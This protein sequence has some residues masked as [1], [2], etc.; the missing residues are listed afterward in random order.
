MNPRMT[1]VSV[2]GLC[3]ILPTLALSASS[4]LLPLHP[5]ATE[6]KAQVVLQ[7][8]QAQ[9]LT[10]ELSLQGL[11]SESVTI[12]GRTMTRLGI[13]AGGEAGAVGQAALPTITRLVAL[14][15]GS[16]VQAAITAMSRHDLGTMSLA[17]NLPILE[18]G[19]AAPTFDLGHY[20][21]A[22]A[23]TPSIEVGE[24]ALMHGL[25]V[26]PITFKP[27]GYDPRTGAVTVA[28]Q[29]TVTVSFTGRDDRNNPVAAPTMIPESFATMFE[30]D[31]IGWEKDPGVATGPGGYIM[32]CPN[33]STVLGIVDKLAQWRQRQGYDV[34]VVTTATT[35]TTNSQISNWLQNQYDTANPPLEFVTLVGDVNG[36]IAMPAHTDNYSGGQGD[37]LY[38]TLEGDDVLSDIHIGRLSVTSTSEL[39]TVIDKIVDYERGPDMS[40]PG[41]F[42][43]AGLTGDPVDSGY[44]CIWV[45]QFVKQQLQELNYTRIDTIWSGNFLSQMMG[46]INQGESLF[47]YRGYWH[48]SG[49][50]SSHIMTLSNDQQLP[51]AVI[52]TCD[53]GTFYQDTNCQSEAFLRAPNGGGIASIGTATTGTHTRYNNCMFLGITNAVLT[54]GDQRV[55]PALT[56]GKVN[57]YRNY[58][59]NEASKVWTWC[60]WNNLMG[61][62]A[63]EIWTAVPAQLDVDYP[64]QVALGANALPVTVSR[65]GSPLSGARVAVFQDGHVRD[66]VLTDASGQAVLNIDGAVAGDVMVTVT[67]QNLHP[68]LGETAVGTVSRSLD[69]ASLTIDEVS[70]NGDD[71]ANPGEVLELNVQVR[72]HGTNSV[73]GAT[74]ELGSALPYLTIL[75]ADGDFGTVP[76]GGTATATF[77][78]LLADAAPGGDTPSLRLDAS[79]SGDLWTSLVPLVI[80]G[81]N[82]GETT[83]TFSGPGGTM[84]PGEYGNLTLPL[85]NQGNAASTGATATLT[86][87][88]A[89]IDVTDNSGAWGPVGIGG[90]SNQNDPFTIQIAS[91]CYT[92]HMAVLQAT[93]S[94]HEGG[95]QVLEFPITVGTA[96]VT[97]PTGPDTYGYYAFDNDDLAPEAPTYDWVELNS[98]GSNT[99]IN[100]HSRHDDET[101]RFDLP[102]D[103]TFYGETYD[104]VSICSNGWLSFG[105]TDIKLYRNWVLP[106]DGSPDA[107]ICAFWDDLAGGSV[108]HYYDNLNHRYI[109]QWDGFGTYYS[110]YPVGYYDGNCTF[111][112][113]LYDPAYHATDSGNGLIVVQYKDLTI[114]A[115]ETTYFTAGIQDHSRTVGLTY[116]Y[117]NNYPA[118]SA[119]V[120]SG[121][122]VAFCTVAPTAQGGI[123]GRVTN[124]S[125]NY[126]P[127]DGALVT[128]LGQGRQFATD[129][130]G[131]FQGSIPVGTWDLAVYHPSFAPDTTYGVAIYEDQVTTVDFSLEDIGGPAIEAV[132]QL[133]DTEDTTGPYTVEARITD[134]SGVAERVLVYTSSATGLPEVQPLTVVDAETGLVSGLIPGQ[135]NGTR[136]QYWITARDDLGHESASPAGA[137]WPTYSFMVAQVTVIAED[138]GES[139]TGWTVNLQGNDNATGG[140]WDHDDPIGSEYNGQQVQT[141]DDH[142]AAP[143]VNCWFTGQHQE[144][145]SAGYNDVD[146]GMTT[147]TSPTYDV[148]D[149]GTVEVNFWRWY[150]NNLGYSPNEDTWLVQ[151]SNDGGSSWS[152]VE[153]TTASNN[154]W[155]QVGVV[156][157]DFFAEPDRLRLRF[158]ASDEG[159][160]SLVE[161]AVDD[162]TIT[163]SSTVA[164]TEA[165][166]VTVT[167]PEEGDQFACYWDV[168]VTWEASDD[169]GVVDTKVWLSIDDGAN[170]DI[171][172]ASGPLAGGIDWYVDLPDDQDYVCR[173]RVDV[174]DGM[175]RTTSAYSGQFFV[176]PVICDTP[177]ISAVLALG[178]NHPNPFNPQTVIAFDLPRSQKASLRIYDVQGRLVTTLVEGELSAGPHR[179][180]WKGCDDSGR[181][182]SSGTYFYRLSTD[183]GQLVK[184]M[185]LLK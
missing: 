93:I 45:N 13:D 185:S 64:T 12:D 54:S 109:V 85:I 142:T 84:D 108:L 120:E 87:D 80:H 76:A 132:T 23:S 40:D 7:D 79:G 83:L 28:D 74:G 73:S 182:V 16:G 49:M 141:E 175:E 150:T 92:G 181:T 57:M 136:V 164:D 163:A 41:W 105:D 68:H 81:P 129:D 176:Y 52:L 139:P 149:L 27:V 18:Q 55:G 86:C 72:N 75:D 126:T 59:Q 101:R 172:L 6:A 133:E 117:G 17:P 140:V 78:V 69:F 4:D 35:G 32:I 111:E 8:R 169:V 131:R 44:S 38:T 143:G 43:T 103:F 100:D 9:G 91:D 31:V 144:G 148:G 58:H 134:H 2:L 67:G 155:Q 118:G 157:N 152:D 30:Q 48:M 39:Q 89:W 1:V 21:N 94:F 71:L 46:T 50:Y 34:Q 165:P 90:T 65:D 114:S 179:L 102:F 10:L 53:T 106:A 25:R 156:A 5:D 95:T 138:D 135:P 88:S 33:N 66:F 162:L 153:N 168:P 96:E 183:D 167:S 19:K 63:T 184:K 166:T 119:T 36:A 124:A 173:I 14:P 24:P 11:T 123:Q 115:D 98:M 37:H 99:G 104:R 62:P 22:E 70:G 127:V 145:Q 20:R 128:V 15:S 116:V 26:V 82:A 147:L 154:A 130:D 125:S 158:R 97:D 151:I 171:L 3:L 61:D 160:G 112:I 47:T 107:M 121:R 122:A 170:Y 174:V 110:G 177:A 159:G 56:A 77:E 178:Q 146:G 137:P 113:I 51:F 60:T 42:T 180:T 29:M 161:A